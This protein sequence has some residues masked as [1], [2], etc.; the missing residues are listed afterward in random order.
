M[1]PTAS[2]TERS[3]SSRRRRSLAIVCFRPLP[4]RLRACFR[5]QFGLSERSFSS[6]A[7][8]F[9][10]AALE[11][12]NRWRGAGSNGPCGALNQTFIMNGVSSSVAVSMKSTALSR[13]TS[14]WYSSVW[15]P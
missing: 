5:S 10:S 1:S 12:V 11:R 6:N 2:S 14:V 15:S 3:C 9:G 4:S 13:S 7:C 8:S